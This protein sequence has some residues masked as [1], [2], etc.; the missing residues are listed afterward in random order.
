MEPEETLS[1]MGIVQF[2]LPAHLRFDAFLNYYPPFPYHPQQQRPMPPAPRGMTAYQPMRP[3][4]QPL[5]RPSAPPTSRTDGPIMNITS[6][7]DIREAITDA[8]QPLSRTPQQHDESAVRGRSRTPSFGFAGKAPTDVSDEPP[9]SA[10]PYP[11]TASV[12]PPV[13]T[14]PPALPAVPVLQ[15]SAPQ[16][17]N[18]L[19]SSCPGKKVRLNGPVKGRG[20]I[21]RSVPQDLARIRSLGVG[22]I[23][24]CLDDGELAFLGASWPDYSAAAAELGIDVLRIP[25]PE[26][27]APLETARLD[28]QLDWVIRNYTLKGIN[29]L[30]HCRGGVG[31]AGLVASSWAIK[32]G[33][34]GATGVGDLKWSTLA[35]RGTLRRDTFEVVAKVVAVMRRRRSVKAIE[36]YEQARFLVDFVE[37]LREAQEPPS[38]SHLQE[39]SVESLNTPNRGSPA[40]SSVG[41]ESETNTEDT[42]VDVDM[43]PATVDTPPE[44]DKTPLAGDFKIQVVDN[45]GAAPV[46]MV[47]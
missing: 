4:A 15:T 26:G 33:L 46:A 25:T 2:A 39:D 44:S 38:P 5:G 37:H 32:M 41:R 20:A 35:A 18:V 21:C 28:S 23:I 42:L 43:S 3:G 40:P 9:L 16:I 45:D 36:T 22:L 27:L 24:N 29:V 10:L 31:R 47:A 12:P 17:G 13:I 19:L 11:L 1:D 6:N 34:C 7:Q 30:V 8:L 14:I